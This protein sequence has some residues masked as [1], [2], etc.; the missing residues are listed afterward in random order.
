MRFNKKKILLLA[1]SC[2]LLAI[3]DFVFAQEESSPILEQ[4]EKQSE[5]KKIKSCEG[6]SYSYDKNGTL[7]KEGHESSFETY[8]KLGDLIE[9]ILYSSEEK[10]SEFTQSKYDSTG[11][12]LDEEKIIPNQPTQKHIYYYKNGLLDYGNVHIDTETV[13]TCTYYYDNNRLSEIIIEHHIAL[14]KDV[15]AQEIIV[16]KYDDKGNKI[17]EDNYEIKLSSERIGSDGNDEKPMYKVIKLISSTSFVYDNNSR[18]IQSSQFEEKTCVGKTE[19]K[20][21]EKGNMTEEIYY[22]DCTDKPE[23]AIKYEYGYY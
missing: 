7:S 19:F 11:K 2:W 14:E 8:N 22:K 6:I 13:H 12:L 17:R 15:P 10:I 4:K 18:I 1:I 9:T 16:C 3:G 21:D 5:L 23:Y 20:Y